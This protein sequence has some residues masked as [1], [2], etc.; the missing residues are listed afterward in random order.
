MFTIKATKRDVKESLEE[1]R[2]AGKVPAVF[3]GHKEDSTPIT[4]SAAEFKKVWSEAGSSS[5]VVLNVD[6]ESHDSLIHDVSVD[7]VKEHVLHADFYILEKGKKVEVETPLEFIGE[8]PAEKAGHILVKVMHEVQI[9]TAS[10]DLPSGIEVDISVL[11]DLGSQI[12]AKDLKLP[13][14]VELMCEPEEVVALIQEANE[15]PER[16]AEAPDL[17]TIEVSGKKKENNESDEEEPSK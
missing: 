8:S 17:S 4:I 7:P 15:E 9:K 1:I 3:Y 16:E 6:D 12:H 2:E 10:K 5:V 13:Q 14:G 11:T